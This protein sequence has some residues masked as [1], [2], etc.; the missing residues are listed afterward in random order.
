[1]SIRRGI[2]TATLGNLIPPLAALITAPLLAQGLGVEGRGEVAA[3]TAPLILATTI[4]T[5]G[6]PESFTYFVARNVLRFRR[7]LVLGLTFLL[8]A[9]LLGSAVISVFALPLSAGD[10]GLAQLI[11]VATT[12]LIPALLVAGLR[13]VASGRQLW[14]RI[15][16]ER[17]L[18]ATFRMVG[19]IVLFVTGDLTPL[20]GTIV[21]SA[22]T[23][24]GGIVY[25]VPPVASRHHLNHRSADEENV[26]VLGYGSR[27]WLGSLAGVLL[28]RLDQL[29]MIP[30]SS[31]TALGLY[32]VAA[33]IS[34]L[35]LIFN[36]AVRDVLFSVES[37][38]PV[39][40]R[41]GQASRLSTLVTAFLGA[42]V[43]LVSPWAIPFFF[44]EDFQGAVSVTIILLVAVVIGNPGSIAGAGLSARGRPELRSA[45]ILIGL[46]VNAALIFTLVPLFG[47]VGAAIATLAGNFVSGNLNIAWMK[48]YFSVPISEFYLL[49]GEDLTL[50]KGILKWRPVQSM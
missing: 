5:F 12:C 36:S 32:A 4:L 41:V 17:S 30:L 22:S 43:A 47:A 24:I 19:V 21:L 48:W 35:I 11:L 20:T 38:S 13:G 16:I 29:M 46:V 33:S 37:R 3:A 40:H 28:M 25:L 2:L 14:K 10:P 6:V 44:G 9:G 49:R 31:A 18:G 50:I 45:S 1:M 8:L 34:E 39:A 27:V 23:V 7:H 42:A 26:K 15:A